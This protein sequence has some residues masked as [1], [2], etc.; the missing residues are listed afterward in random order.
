MGCHERLR[1]VAR[2]LEREVLTELCREFGISHKTDYKICNRYKE[3]G[4]NSV[5]GAKPRAR[6]CSM[7][8]GWPAKRRKSDTVTAVGIVTRPDFP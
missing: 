2:L 1:F 7:F 6:K 3:F 4:C 8:K 5:R